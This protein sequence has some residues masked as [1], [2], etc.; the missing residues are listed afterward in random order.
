MVRNGEVTLADIKR[1]L[2]AYWWILPIT[3]VA[4]GCLAMVAIKVLPKKFTS[5]TMVLVEPPVVPKEVV[6]QVVTDDLYHH[7]AS[8]QEQILSTSGLQPIIEKY[9]L[10]TEKRGKEHMEESVARLRKAVE[11]ELIQPIQGSTSRQPPGFHIS[12]TYSDALTAQEICSE[13]TSMFTKRHAET[14]L[15]RGAEQTKFLNSQLDE[16]KAKLDEQDAKLAAFQREHMGSLPD[17]EQANLN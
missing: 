8:I 7:L 6:P 5:S 1:I 9:N 4:L 17:Q 13:L 16:A 2:R 11:V 10:Y 3:T 12:V 15:I 14:G